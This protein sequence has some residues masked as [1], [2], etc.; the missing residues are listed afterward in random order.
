MRIENRKIPIF[1]MG[2]T[3]LQ[4]T[5][6][7]LEMGPCCGLEPQPCTIQGRKNYFGSEST[8]TKERGSNVASLPVLRSFS[9]KIFF[10][11]NWEKPS[12]TPLKDTPA[13]FLYS[14][15]EPTGTPLSFSGKKKCS[16]KLGLQLTSD[17]LEMEAQGGIE[18]PR[19]KP[20]V[21]KCLRHL[22]PSL[23]LF[24]PFE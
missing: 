1:F 5:S 2:K 22:P 9:V 3:G 13:M 7:L 19:G 14:I 8:S 16:I 15:F 11:L 10:P 24:W 18:P 4:L 12:K 20:A 17:L 21:L 6:D 23:G